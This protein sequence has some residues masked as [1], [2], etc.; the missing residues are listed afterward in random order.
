MGS[1]RGKDGNWEKKRWEVKKEKMGSGRG[2]DEK[3]KRQ[4]WKVVPK[5]Q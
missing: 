4:G 2:K 5:L 3:C 1:G